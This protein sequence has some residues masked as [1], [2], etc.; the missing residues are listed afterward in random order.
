[1]STSCSCINCNI[2]FA[3]SDSLRI[4]QT[5]RVNCSTVLFSCKGNIRSQISFG[6]PPPF[7][8][9]RYVVIECGRLMA[10]SCSR[11]ISVCRFANCSVCMITFCTFV[12]NMSTYIRS[13]GSKTFANKVT[14]SGFKDGNNLLIFSKSVFTDNT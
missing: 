9:C 7:S 11:A 2:S 3:V 13:F 14:R 12:R 6:S 4:D 8:C 10:A 5:S 1:M